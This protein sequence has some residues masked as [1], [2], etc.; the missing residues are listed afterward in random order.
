MSCEF[1]DLKEYFFGESSPEDRRRAEGHVA[2]CE[3]CRDELS[4]LQMTQAA[5][6][7]LRDEELPRR[8]AFVSDKV[9]EPRW[10]QRLWRSG[11]QLGFVGAGL[12]ACAILVHAFVQRPA[13]AVPPPAVVQVDQATIERLVNERIGDA[14]TKAV[15]AVEA[16]QQTKTVELLQAAERKYDLDRRATIEAIAAQTSMIQRMQSRDYALAN[17]LGSSQ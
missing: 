1:I 4:R 8:I 7:A 15:A 13:V 9:F 2:V 12:L 14:V 6:G 10:Y 3:A 5:L 16:R 17:N 11:P